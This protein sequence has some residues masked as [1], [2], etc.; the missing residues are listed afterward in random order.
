MIR[1][2]PWTSLDGRPD[3][4]H[5]DR[6]R[7]RALHAALHDLQAEPDEL[8]NVA[9]GNKEM[10]GEL[11]EYVTSGIEPA[12]ER[13]QAARLSEEQMDPETLER[14]RSLGYIR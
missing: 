5:G 13:Q 11:R 6:Y 14:L 9:G 10:A 2:E 3:R 4:L 8:L 12:P 7:R 1:Y